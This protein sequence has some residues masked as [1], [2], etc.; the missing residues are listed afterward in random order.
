MNNLIEKCKTKFISIYR[1]NGLDSDLEV[2][3]YPLLADEA[4]GKNAEGDFV[5]KKGKEFVIQAEILNSKGQAFTDLPSKYRG[6]IEDILKL[7]LN[8][9]KN[10]ALFI[11]AMNAVLRYLN[12]THNTLHC[13]DESPSL[14]GSEITRSVKQKYGMKKIL[15]VG[16]QPAILKALVELFKPENIQVLDLN[17]E[18]IGSKVSGVEVFNGEKDLLKLTEWCDLGLVTGSTIVNGTIDGIISAFERLEKKY[19]FFGNTISGVA[20]LLNLEHICPFSL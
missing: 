11:A 12:M 3:I 18:K 9:S 20:K 14:C 13:K 17:P 16:L 10:R 5:I 19:I 2:K 7:P 1:E 4:I 8:N 15:L 6:T